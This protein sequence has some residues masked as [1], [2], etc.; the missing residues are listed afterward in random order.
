MNEIDDDLFVHLLMYRPATGG[1]HAVLLRGYSMSS[2][3]WSI[4]DPLYDDFNTFDMGSSYITQ[5][6]CVYQYGGV[7]N[8]G[9]TIYDLR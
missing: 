7:S 3:T 4:W 8:N 2:M 9:A 1:S 5:T 6:G